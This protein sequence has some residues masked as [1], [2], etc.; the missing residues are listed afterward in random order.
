MDMIPITLREVAEWTRGRLVNAEGNEKISGVSTD[1]RKICQ[2][3][4]F[5]ALK[6]ERF[7]GHDFVADAI[8][9]GRRQSSLPANFHFQFRKSSWLTPLGL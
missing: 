9:K 6:G 1:S 7:D 5:V 4:L 3:D 8:Q 2:G